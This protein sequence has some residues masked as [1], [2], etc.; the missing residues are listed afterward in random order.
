[1][2]KCSCCHHHIIGFVSSIDCIYMVFSNIA[3]LLNGSHL[4]PKA[5]RRIETGGIVFQVADHLISGH[6]PV[7]VITLIMKSRKL[8]LPVWGHQ[9]ERI[10]SFLPAGCYPLFFLQDHVLSVLLG[11][12]IAHR[13]SCLATADDNC[14]YFFSI[15]DTVY[16]HYIDSN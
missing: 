9:G 7:R 10:P 15:H 2:L 8:Q 4:H 12:Q 6:E 14:I 16:L 13:Q 3:R 11:Q 1:M 5:N